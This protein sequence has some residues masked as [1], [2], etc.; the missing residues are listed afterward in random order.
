NKENPNVDKTGRDI[1]NFML[2]MLIYLV[3]SIILIFVI[4][5]IPLLIILGIL[6]IIFIIVAAV[7]T[8]NDKSWTYPMT[9]KFF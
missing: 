7:R 6:E 8:S 5:G 2:S 3:I 4:I 1:L 9:I